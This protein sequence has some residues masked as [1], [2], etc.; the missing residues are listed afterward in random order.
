VCQLLFNQ[1]YVETDVEDHTVGLLGGD[2]YDAAG[3]PYVMHK[4]CGPWGTDE[5]FQCS[6]PDKVSNYHWPHFSL[7]P[8]VWSVKHMK[9]LGPIEA[10]SDFEYAHGHKYVEAGL[11]TAFLPG[12]RAIHIGKPITKSDLDKQHFEEALAKH[13]IY[14]PAVGK[15]AYDLTGT[16]R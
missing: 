9:T 10:C 11:K 16:H 2:E 3:V 4:Y 5:Y 6:Q 15:S 1:D 8:G 13:G 12:A 14:M 7:R